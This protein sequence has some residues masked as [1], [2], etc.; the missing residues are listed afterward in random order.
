MNNQDLIQKLQRARDAITEAL[1]ALAGVDLTI[2]HKPTELQNQMEKANK[3]KSCRCGNQ[4]DYYGP[5]G[6]FSVQCF[7]CNQKNAKRQRD[8]RSKKAEST[9]YFN[10]DKSITLTLDLINACRTP[11]NGFT[12]KTIKAFGYE[13]FKYAKKGW[14]QELVGKV[15]T[16]SA[17]QAALDGRIRK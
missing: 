2:E 5:V 13:C 11:R 15:I 7:D 8:A 14:I 6:G 17:Y 10:Q 1:A 3:P 4:L 16:Q 12:S 9:A